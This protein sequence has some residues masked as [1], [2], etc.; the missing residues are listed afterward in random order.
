MKLSVRE[1][2]NADVN[3]IVKYQLAMAMETESLELDKDILK[4]G[5]D[6]VLKDPSKARYFIAEK[7]G[8]SAGM[9]MITLEWSDWRNGWVWWIQSVYTAP[10]YRGQGVY[11]QL[12]EHIKSLVTVSDNI[13]GIR[14]YV[15]NRN[16][17][18]QKVYKSLGM[19][20]D[21]YTTYEWMRDDS[22]G[23]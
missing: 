20:G 5:V 3:T 2:N 19:N 1:A 7:D 4:L 22:S 16:L 23:A 21:H 17:T 13:R 11:K 8:K 10:E 12:Y 6:A 9:L 18:A 14:L 15:D